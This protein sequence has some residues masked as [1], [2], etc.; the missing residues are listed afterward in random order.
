MRNWKLN[1]GYIGSDQRRTK[2]GSYDVRKHYLER[3]NGQ[4][5]FSNLWTPAQ[6]STALWLDANDP[7]TITLNGSTVSQWNDKSG[8]ARHAVQGTAG[9]Q[10]TRVLSGL[11]SKTILR[12]NGINDGSIMTTTWNL[13]NSHS[14]FLVAKKSTQTSDA[15][16][17]V[18]PLVM[19]TS[20]GGGII[21]GIGTLRTGLSSPQI[22]TADFVMNATRITVIENSW[23]DNVVRLLNYTYN[24]TTMNGWLDGSTFSTPLTASFSTFGAINIGGIDDITQ[25]RFAGD[26][27]ETIIVSSVTSTTDRQLI[28]GYLA[29]K[30]GLQANLP[31]GHP[32]KNNPPTA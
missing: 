13:T 14:I 17:I 19:S 22:N 9:K 28:E 26:L 25:R 18:R 8:N 1:S 2:T 15:A 11:N 31:I 21:A 5:E 3:I 16:S 4:F 10:P 24:G 30:W 32:Y 12:F 7:S 23:L 27:A 6:I 29:W 20:S